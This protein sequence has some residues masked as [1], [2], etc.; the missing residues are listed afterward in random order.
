MK[1]EYK[2][3]KSIQKRLIIINLKLFKVDPFKALKNIDYYRLI[4][5]PVV[6]KALKIENVKGLKILDI[7]SLDSIF[8]LF[9]AYN[10]HNVIASDINPRVKVLEMY[11][12]K[13]GNKGRGIKQLSVIRP[14]FIRN[15]RSFVRHPTVTVGFLVYQHVR[16]FSAGLGY[17]ASMVR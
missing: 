4:E 3:V 17:L 16:Y 10:G 1:Y 15:W 9:L 2:Y 14:S 12:K 11:A 8:P 6:Y 7:G 5:Y 13:L